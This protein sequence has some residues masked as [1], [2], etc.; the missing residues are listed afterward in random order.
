M[1][2]GT[3]G[4]VREGYSL[5]PRVRGLGPGKFFANRRQKYAFSRPCLGSICLFH[6][7]IF[8]TKMSINLSFSSK[9]IH[10]VD[11][12]FRM[13]TYVKYTGTAGCAL[14]ISGGSRNFVWGAK[15]SFLVL[16]FIPFSSL[17]IPF[18][19]ITLLP[20]SPSLSH[21]TPLLPICVPNPLLSLPSFLSST[22]L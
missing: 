20:A 19:C 17:P 12:I 6:H 11:S 7:F 16:S 18:L 2:W 5:A 1:V 22:P 9:C 3:R 14:T 15:S 21:T 10:E 13:K 8:G 4:R